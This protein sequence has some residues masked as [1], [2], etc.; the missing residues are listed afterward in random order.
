MDEVD[1]RRD[2][3]ALQADELV[4][5]DRGRRFGAPA[6]LETGEGSADLGTFAEL[7]DEAGLRCAECGDVALDRHIPRDWAVR[8]ADR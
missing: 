4:A 2:V 5:D 3:D 8:A 6:G 7:A 1:D